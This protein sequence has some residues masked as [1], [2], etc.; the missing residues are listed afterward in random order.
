MGAEAGFPSGLGSKSARRTLRFGTW[1]GPGF[2]RFDRG[3]V[4]GVG[5][6]CFIRFWRVSSYEGLTP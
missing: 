6:S 4:L 2:G 1:N 3:G 5:H